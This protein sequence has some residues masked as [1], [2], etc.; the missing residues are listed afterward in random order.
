MLPARCLYVICF[1]PFHLHNDAI[2]RLEYHVASVAPTKLLTP[3]IQ[4]KKIDGCS[5]TSKAKQTKIHI[6][7]N[8]PRGQPREAR[9]KG[10]GA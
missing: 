7:R 8:L 6:Y 2:N 9:A 4:F 1:F 10:K 3:E 5:F